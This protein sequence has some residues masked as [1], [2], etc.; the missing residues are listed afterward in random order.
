MVCIGEQLADRQ[1]G[2][3]MDVC[4]EQLE[5]V[6]KALA[7]GDWKKVV[8]AYEP[9]WAIGTGVTASPAQAQETHAQVREWL[10][11][12]VSKAVAEETRIIYGGSATAANCDELYAQP[13]INGFLVGGASMKE[14]FVKIINCTK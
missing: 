14:E 13:D 1:K 11:K 2:T 9:V 6:K 10:V 7:I 4:S 8:I 3:T 5:A 12:N